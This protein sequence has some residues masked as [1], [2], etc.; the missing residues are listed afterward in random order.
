MTP[1]E[2]PSLAD[3]IL[4]PAW[5]RTDQL[6]EMLA[7]SAW[8]TRAI[9]LRHP[10]IFYLGHLAAFAWNHIGVGVLGEDPHDAELD[11]LFERGI[12]PLSDEAA[13]SASLADWP[14]LGR[15]RAYRDA[16]RERLRGVDEA[17]AA[18]ADDVLAREARVMWLVREHEE[19]HH[20]TLL[21]LFQE[22]D[23]RWLRKPAGW[24]RLRVGGEPREARFVP[25]FG[26]PAVMGEDLDALPF[27]WDNESPRHEV[28]V[29]RFLLEDLPVTNARFA[30]FVQDG[31]YA[32]KGLWDEAD[33]AWLEGLQRD[34]PHA[35]RR[36]G[37]DAFEVRSLFAWH[38]LAEVAGWPVQLSLAEARAFARWSDARLPTE[39]ELHRATWMDR[40]GL[41]HTPWRQGAVD[42]T[43]S[44]FATGGFEPVLSR[45]SGQG[46]WG[47][48][49]LV[50]NCWTW[51]DTPFR[52]FEGMQTWHHTY[53]GYSTDFFDDQHFVV[54]GASWATAKGLTR[55][56]FRN[57][58]QP[59]YPYVF[60]GVRLA[61]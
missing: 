27:A 39:A 61:R 28:E 10:P 36:A 4:A 5:A 11:V 2:G 49:D 44:G 16:I 47:H 57:W 40:D 24:P 56:S 35:W 60:A 26:G 38:P 1:S 30:A 15:I 58:Y 8:T 46:P 25:V 19:M 3:E 50:G 34:H 9:P 13:T 31:G 14:D 18:K 22:L 51:T 54:H 52:P 53:P 20:E 6:F 43:N 59:H 41:R 48:H 17:L 29:E 45:R 37:G 42:P 33:H 7:P 32:D 23:P 12:D 55:R 21:Y